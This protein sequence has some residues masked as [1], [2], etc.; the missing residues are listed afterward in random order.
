MVTSD[1]V[2]R[3][4]TLP[5]AA[6]AAVLLLAGCTASPS[7]DPEVAPTDAPIVESPSPEATEEAPAE[8]YAAL[9]QERFGDCLAALNVTDPLVFTAGGDGTQQL[10]TVLGQTEGLLLT[11]SVGESN[12]GA[13]ITVPADDATTTALGTVGC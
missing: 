4:R 8:D 2:E 3:M 12:T 6:V 1:T 7:S 5:I 11:F 13:I 9:V 10:G